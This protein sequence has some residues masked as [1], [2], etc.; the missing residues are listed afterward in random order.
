MLVYV[1]RR[2]SSLVLTLLIMMLVVFVLFRV[3]PGDPA[4][5]AAGRFTPEERVEEIREEMGFNK[6]VYIQ[7]F[8]Y[9]KGLLR[10]DFGKSLYTKR[11]VATDLR[12][13]LPA[14]IELAFPSLL[15]A[16]LF[17]IP[18]GIICAVSQNTWVDHIGRLVSISGVSLPVFW[19][20]LMAQWALYLRLG[21]LP[22]MGRLPA[23]IGAPANLTGFYL[24]DSL[25]TQNWAVLGNV[26]L[27][28][29]LPVSCLAFVIIGQVSRMTRSSMLNV[30]RQDYIQT[31]RAK[32][33]TSTSVNFKHAF[34]NASLPILTLTG[35][36]LGQLLAGVVLTETIFSW[37]GIGLYLVEA[38]MRLD[39]QPVLG[40]TVLTA[41]IYMLLN[42]IIDLLYVYVDPR[43][44]LY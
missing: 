18:I 20:A 34:R 29:V 1:L 39:T 32:G 26:I 30:L 21:L 15:L 19:V 7:F 5:L 44:R 22:G 27:H 25:L 33:L 35:Q 2:I 36:L 14:T 41:M 11:P 8:I 28:L 10:F 6:P 13:Y 12:T 9:I 38:I 43:I 42:L 24:L 31:A 40:F 23:T 3:I 4:R 16:L 37:P 17:G